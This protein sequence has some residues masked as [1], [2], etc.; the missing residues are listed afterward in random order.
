MQVHDGR[1]VEHQVVDEFRETD[2][3]LGDLGRCRAIAVGRHMPDVPLGPQRRRGHA[4]NEARHAA[5]GL[6]T[7]R[8]PQRC[9]SS[10]ACRPQAR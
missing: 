2:D 8:C 9:P 3:K 5:P 4:T 10:P 6:Q 7:G 1:S